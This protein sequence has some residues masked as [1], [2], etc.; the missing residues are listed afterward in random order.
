MVSLSSLVCNLLQK[1]KIHINTDFAFTG[2]MLC[3]IPHIR[4]DAKYHSESDHRKQNLGWGGMLAT[5]DC[6]R[7]PAEVP[8]AGVV[9]CAMR[10]PGHRDGLTG[11]RVCVAGHLPPGP[12][13]G[14]HGTYPQEGNHWSTGQTGRYWPP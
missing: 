13:S 14:D 3:V 7:W 12:F 1:R 8:P 2:W 11:G 4:K 5:A 9:L 10:H 6:L